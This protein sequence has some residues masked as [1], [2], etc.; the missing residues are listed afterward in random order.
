VSTL[1]CEA[2][3]TEYEDWA[4]RC[5]NCG[6]VL[7]PAAEAPNPLLLPEEEQVVYEL[8]V[9]PLDQQADAAAAMAESGIP[10]AWDGTDLVVHIDHE[11]Q[12][13]AIMDEIER[14][15]GLSSAE[16]TAA[17]GNG[18]AGESSD[19]SDGEAGERDSGDRDTGDRGELVYDLSEWT[20]PQREVLNER[21][22]E[23]DIP[24]RWEDDGESLVVASGDEGLV[25]QILDS[26]EFPDALDAEEPS[27][28]EGEADEAR[29]ELLSELFIAADRLKGS[30]TDAEAYADLLKA[31]DEADPEL[32]P[33]GFPKVVW[34][35][36]V[37]QAN[38]LADLIADEEDRTDE[39]EEQ[40]QQLRD[41][42]RPYV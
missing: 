29:A 16:P 39:A 42:L 38:D 32:P 25:E 30:T 40:A 37:D 20:Q 35:Q 18:A 27:A 21:L 33:Y 13:D 11:R 19:A 1:V 10:H 26:V 34:T 23:G 5:P 2:C 14:E 36:A 17:E 24:H 12:V 3:G 41:L 6:I 15:A 4:T 8:G 7:V 31:V 22:N 28:E 9:W